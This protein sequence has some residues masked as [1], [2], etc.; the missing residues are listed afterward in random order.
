MSRLASSIRRA[1]PYGLGLLLFA[2][3][4]AL[5]NRYQ[6]THDVLY[7]LAAGDWSRAGGNVTLLA[8]QAAALLLAFCLLG[9]RAFAAALALAI[10]S[11]GVNLAYG[12]TLG[13]TL[14][15]GKLAWMAGEARQ[16]GNA[17]GEFAG[18]FALAAL[19]AFAAA[20]LF[21]GARA[22]MR[23]RAAAPATAVQLL[24]FAVLI[25][26][27]FVAPLAGL[28]PTAAERNL[29][30]LVGEVVLAAPPPPRE[31]V[32]L[33][34]GPDDSLRHIVW[35]VDE[36]IAYRPFERLI[37]PGLRGIDHLDFGMAAALGHC[38]TPSNLALRSGVDVRR[39]GP[40]MDLRTTPSIWA[41]AR[42]AGYRTL[43]IDG[44]THGAPQNMLLPPERALIDE[45]RPM[46]GSLDTDVR[47]AE[48]LNRQFHGPGR[49]FTYVVLRGVH[50]QYRDHFPAGTIP[51]DSPP[52]R[53][54]EAALTYSKSRFF[55]RLLHG[56]DRGAVAVVYT[57]D[58]GQN[59]R[60]GAIPHCSPAPDPVELQVPLLAFLPER[61]AASYAEAP[62]SGHAASQILPATLIWMGYDPAA[63][64]QRYDND[65]TLA[66]ARY[67]RF[68][69]NVVPLRLGDAVGVHASAR[70]PGAPR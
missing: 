13:D 20:A 48:A 43:L 57:S 65:L 45:L 70:F 52:A 21:I 24:G 61:L 9:R 60:P 36:S 53:Q 41:Y 37:A 67:V 69:R 10:V 63:V 12:Q 68:E 33:E 6:L 18:P 27:N 34:P 64:Q 29:Y 23:R 7:R 8:A 32:D 19:Q 2:A 16:A 28:Q 66:P 39:A 50:F 31:P 40:Q 26:P 1:W 56:V 30:S 11:I 46:A 4:F 54:Y 49:T 58:H 51:A 44:Q 55:D 15:A 25:A 17:A 62:R 22:A 35:L 3:G 38:S 14:D 42:K 5:A 59:L 47:I